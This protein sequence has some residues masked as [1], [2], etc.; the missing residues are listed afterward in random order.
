MSKVLLTVNGKQYGGWKEVR[1]TR[2]MEAIAGGFE[3]E[4]SEKF[5]LQNEPWPI[6]PDDTCTLSIDGTTLITGFVDKRT[7]SY[8]HQEHGVQVAGRDRTGDLVDCSVLLK[9]WSFANQKADQIIA[10]IC[11]PF[12]ISVSVAPGVT[13]PP[14]RGRFPIQPGESCFEA[15]DRVCR[16]NGLLPISDG[17]GGI[18][19]SHAGTDRVD[20]T[21]KY[22]VNIIRARGDF[23]VSR[24][25]ARYVVRGQGTGSDASFGEVVAAV[26]AESTDAGA[27]AGRVLVLRPE[28]AVTIKQAQDRCNWEAT[29]RAAR[30]QEFTVTVQ[31]WTQTPGGAVWPINKL[32]RYTD[33]MTAVDTDMLIAQ[34]VFQ[35]TIKG[36]TVTELTLR[37]PD[38]FKPEP[39][40]PKKQ[41]TDTFDFGAA[42]LTNPDD[43]PTE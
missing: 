43:E 4:V 17:L 15:I 21:L 37:R 39:L 3:L 7:P 26:H 31:G 10:K 11:A 16:M 9:V 14:P 33:P 12:G 2:S 36:G 38:A 5:P 35:Q 28:G 23:D 30:T 25:F 6:R 27:R 40:I 22:G 20:V 18:V 32:V 13:I 1:V 29:V 8:D 19:L 24:R 41:P 42:N 34:T